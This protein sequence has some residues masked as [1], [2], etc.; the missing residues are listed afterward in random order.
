MNKESPNWDNSGNKNKRFL[1]GSKEASFT[2]RIQE[3]EERNLG[4][5]Y[6][7]EEMDNSVK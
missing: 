4:F 5:E 6:V 1:S 3:T 7:I 2:Y